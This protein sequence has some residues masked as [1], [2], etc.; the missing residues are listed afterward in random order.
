[1]PAVLSLSAGSALLLWLVGWLA[2]GVVVSLVMGRRGHDPFGWLLVGA[3]LGPLALPVAI[4]TARRPNV[5][6]PPWR[7]AGRHGSG[8]VDVLVG[9]DGSPHAAAALDAAVDLLGPRLGRL[10]LVAVSTLDATAA[11]REEEARLGD[12]LRRQAGRIQ[13]RLGAAGVDAAAELVLLRGQPAHTLTDYAAG[14][15]YALLVVGTRGAGLTHRL[16]GSVAESLA[17]G[18]RVPVL[19]AGGP[20]GVRPTIR[21]GQRRAATG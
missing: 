10:T 20:A 19:L 2:T 18:T 4:S 6:R 21:G 11:R 15:G 9:I 12:E 16:L 5:V 3:I 17:A 13:A 8:R 14:H 7:T 1:M